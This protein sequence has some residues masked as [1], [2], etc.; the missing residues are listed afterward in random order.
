MK[1]ANAPFNFLDFLPKIIPD[2]VGI[3][4]LY[5]FMIDYKKFI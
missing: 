4:Y 2:S 1:A 5:L 3:K